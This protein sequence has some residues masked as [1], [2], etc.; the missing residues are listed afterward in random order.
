[1]QTKTIPIKQTD[2]KLCT[3]CKHYLHRHELDNS[4][5]MFKTSQ[6]V[7]TGYAT[8]KHVR[9]A[10]DKDSLSGRLL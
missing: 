8:Y 5:A 3:N 7:L 10:R 9:E 2:F 1:M 6:D 4:C